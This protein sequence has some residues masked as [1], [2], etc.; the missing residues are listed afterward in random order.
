MAADARSL[1]PSAHCVLARMTPRAPH[2]R[3]LGSERFQNAPDPFAPKASNRGP[4]A[5][6]RDRQV[7]RAAVGIEVSNG[8]SHVARGEP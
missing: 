7:S 6:T 5:R 2:F 8:V 3:L 1:A 4:E